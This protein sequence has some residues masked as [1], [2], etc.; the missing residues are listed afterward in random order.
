MPDQHWMLPIAQY[1][2]DFP[3]EYTIIT[4][5]SVSIFVGVLQFLVNRIVWRS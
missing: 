5:V 1:A 3:M 2:H 4:L